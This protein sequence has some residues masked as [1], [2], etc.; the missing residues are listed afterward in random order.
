MVSGDTHNEK[1]DIWSLGI[2]CYEF[3]VGVPPFETQT[4]DETYMRI[5]D[6][7]LKFPDTMSDDVCDLISRILVKDPTKRISLQDILGHPWI[8]KNADLWQEEEV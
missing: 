6:V 8:V 3:C 5:K 4:H 2:L 7:D 1:V